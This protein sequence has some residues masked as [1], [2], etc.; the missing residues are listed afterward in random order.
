MAHKKAGGSTNNGR[1]SQP[2][3]R[4]VKK[5]GGERVTPG[6]IIVRQVGTRFHPGANVGMGRDFTLYAL[7]DG[8]VQF[9]QFNKKR[10]VVSVV[11]A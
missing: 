3:M 6:N 5:Y 10:K 8:W 2:K 11:P 9:T 1:D 4:G 7:N